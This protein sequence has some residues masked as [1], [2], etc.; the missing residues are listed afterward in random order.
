[1][2]LFTHGIVMPKYGGNVCMGCINANSRRFHVRPQQILVMGS[3][4]QCEHLTS[5]VVTL[6]VPLP[7]NMTA[8]IHSTAVQTVIRKCYKVFSRNIPGADFMEY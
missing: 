4:A 2:R 5:D 1:M 6:S 3:I 8:F 7:G